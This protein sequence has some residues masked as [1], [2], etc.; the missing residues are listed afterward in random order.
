MI[1]VVVWSSED[2][3]KAV[4]WCED[5][6]ALAY[7]HGR[8]ELFQGDQWPNAGELLELESETIGSIRYARSVV[9]LNERPCPEIPAILRGDAA[10]PPRRM[11]LVSSRRADHHDDGPQPVTPRLSAAR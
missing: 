10:E 7:L 1:G 2:H 11:R 5:H 3:L 6:G 8:D 9:R 4:V